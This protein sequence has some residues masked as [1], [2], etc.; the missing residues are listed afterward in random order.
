MK[1]KHPDKDR[2]DKA[3]LALALSAALNI[4]EIAAAFQIDESEARD[5]VA[6]GKVLAGKSKEIAS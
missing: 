1:L 2:D 4:R 5:L 3:G 6:R